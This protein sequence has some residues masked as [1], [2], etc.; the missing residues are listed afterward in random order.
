MAGE[1]TITH[2]SNHQISSASFILALN[3]VVLAATTD[4][5][6]IIP[7]VGDSGQVSI[8]AANRAT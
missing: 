2:L 7:T 5:L 1:I 6:F 3:S 8:V 4:H